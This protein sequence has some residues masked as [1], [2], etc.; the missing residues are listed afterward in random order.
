MNDVPT[1]QV[2]I[3]IRRTIAVDTCR[4]HGRGQCKSYPP[5]EPIRLHV[6]SLRVSR[7]LHKCVHCC[8][9]K[10][11]ERLCNIFFLLIKEA[12]STGHRLERHPASATILPSIPL[13]A[14]GPAEYA[15]VGGSTGS[16]GSTGGSTDGGCIT[17]PPPPPQ[18]VRDVAP[19]AMSPT[20]NSEVQV[21][22][23]TFPLLWM[24]TGRKVVFL[25]FFILSSSRNDTS[26][27]QCN[28]FSIPPM[29]T[30]RFI[31]L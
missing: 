17:E 2:R 14:Y 26:N 11:I 28:L 6:Q 12:F 29:R 21:L 13:I 18:A 8:P 16:T 24:S 10:A 15:E 27:L 19:I 23:F 7:N 3:R 30:H 31:A 4:K 1:N 20:N 22:F 25:L 5:P 9:N